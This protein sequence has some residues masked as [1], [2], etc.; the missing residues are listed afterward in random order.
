MKDTTGVK[1]EYKLYKMSKL[2]IK[3]AKIT[4]PEWIEVKTNED[5]DDE[6]YVYQLKEVKCISQ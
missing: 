6:N 3:F 4:K 2:D 1:K 5:R